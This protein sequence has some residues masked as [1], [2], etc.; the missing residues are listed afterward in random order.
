MKKITLLI[1]FLLMINFFLGVTYADEE[2]PDVGT[3]DTNV[4]SQVPNEENQDE[5][6]EVKAKVL[7]ASEPKKIE[8]GSMEDTVQ[9]VKVE[10]LEG[11]YDTQEFTTNY[12]LSYDIEGR[13]LA[14]EL[15]PGDKVWVQLIKKPDGK[16]TIEIENTV[17]Q[18]YIY[19]MLILFLLSIILVGGKRGIKAIIGLIITVLAVYFIL[20]KGILAGYNPIMMSIFTSLVIIVLTFIIIG[21]G[22]AGITAS[23]YLKKNIY[24]WNWNF[25]RSSSS[26]NS[27]IYI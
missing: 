25:W 21:G 10:I 27:C 26:W 12:I 11:E 24:S 17:R 7:E 23:I 1:T 18:N 14:Y 5:Y 20:I 22:I 19:F 8:N 3:T 13:I 16:A 15:K 6:F 4:E 2:N 9:E